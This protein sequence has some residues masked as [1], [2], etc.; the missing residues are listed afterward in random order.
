LEKGEVGEGRGNMIE[1]CGGE[2]ERNGDRSL[3]KEV[4][5]KV[6]GQQ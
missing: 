6:N 2:F 3:E 1:R 4:T 5:G